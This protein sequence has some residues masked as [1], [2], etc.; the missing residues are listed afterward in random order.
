MNYSKVLY[1]TIFLLITLMSCSSE[2]SKT[3]PKPFTIEVVKTDAEIK[4]KCSNGCDWTEL[5]IIKNNYHPQLVDENGMVDSD[6]KQSDTKESK[7]ANFLFS[8]TRTEGGIS[9]TGYHGTAWKNL[10]FSLENNQ[11][12]LITQLGMK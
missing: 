1:L 10:G 9:L 3:E 7:I 4:L 11:P 2:S 6:K 8:I 12:Q 5:N